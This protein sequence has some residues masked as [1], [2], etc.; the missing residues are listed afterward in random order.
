MY[1]LSLN[2]VEGILWSA[3]I[4]CTDKRAGWVICTGLKAGFI[5]MLGLN[6][7]WRIIY[8]ANITY[9]DLRAGWVIYR[10]DRLCWC[11]WPTTVMGT[12]PET[13]LYSRLAAV[14]L[15]T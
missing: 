6:T 12:L 7:A 9:T 13:L 15:L 10:G 1:G 8:D 2:A 11:W 3:D 14:F 5:F 4:T